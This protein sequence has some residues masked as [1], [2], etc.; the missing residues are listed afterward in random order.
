MNK[1]LIIIALSM[2]SLFSCGLGEGTIELN[3]A[4]TVTPDIFNYLHDYEKYPE[5]WFII[6][7]IKKFDRFEDQY[8]SDG[9][10]DGKKKRIPMYKISY[11][12]FSRYKGELRVSTGYENYTVEV[13]KAMEVKI[14]DIVTL[15]DQRYITSKTDPIILAA[16]TRVEYTPLSSPKN[17]NYIFDDKWNPDFQTTF[18][19]GK[20]IDYQKYRD[21]GI[22]GPICLVYGV[23]KEDDR[24]SEISIVNEYG[25]VQ[26]T[27]FPTELVKDTNL[28]KGDIIEIQWKGNEMRFKKLPMYATRRVTADKQ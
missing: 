7:N 14:G 17:E 5:G 19:G 4:Y 23:R 25:F 9:Y 28:K 20:V 12:R 6:S 22:K 24:K 1:L 16:P 18:A 10:N 3:K 15:Q 2:I 11:S 26:S 13:Y 27:Y 21:E 8:N